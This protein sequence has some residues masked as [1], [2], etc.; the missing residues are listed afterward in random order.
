MRA[1]QARLLHL[2]HDPRGVDGAFGPGTYAAVIAF[3][4][5]RQLRPDGV[6]GP[7]TLEALEL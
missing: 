3:Q 6:A 7:V 2:G 5:A 1:L 4:K